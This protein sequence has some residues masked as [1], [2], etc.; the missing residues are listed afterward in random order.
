MGSKIF[1]CVT[2]FN[3]NFI[4]NARFEILSHVVD[5]FVVC[6]SIYD[7]RGQKKKLNFHL[8]NQKYKSKIIYIVLEDKFESDDLWINQAQQREYIFNGLKL[9]NKND[10]VMFSDPD[11]IPNPKKLENFN[12][13][14]KYGI[15]LQDCF[16]YKINI[17]NKYE[18][19]WEGTRIC[20]KENLTSIN[21]MR[22]KVVS[23]NLKYNFFRFDKEKN[24]QLIEN[25]GWHFNNLMS[26]QNISLKLKTFAHSEYANDMYSS[27]KV[28]EEKIKKKTD[29][30]NRGHIYEVRKINHEYP[31][32]ILDNLKT[33]KDFID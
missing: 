7:H 4:L 15:F 9:A 2:F 31:K 14:R 27:V 25:G 6:E 16:C 30:F 22:Q 29:L 32:Y 10:Y 8:L 11:E 23:K 19:P 18:S 24:I 26:P 20:K 5:Y 21:Y 12:L 3:E 28:I 13:K 17:F 33:F 1:D